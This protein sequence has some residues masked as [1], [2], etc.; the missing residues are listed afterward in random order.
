M[1]NHR[2]RIVNQQFSDILKPVNILGTASASRCDAVCQDLFREDIE[3][4][5]NFEI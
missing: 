4:E 5:R 1:D 2:V 3:E